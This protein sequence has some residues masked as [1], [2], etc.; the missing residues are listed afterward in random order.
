MSLLTEERI[1]FIA[2]EL[3]KACQDD[4]NLVSIE[5][6]EAALKEAENAI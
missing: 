6:L 5:R 1:K 2:D 4:S 3:Y